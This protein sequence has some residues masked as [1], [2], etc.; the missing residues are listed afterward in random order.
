MPMITLK[1][2]PN[3]A[4]HETAGVGDPMLAEELVAEAYARAFARWRNVAKHPAPAAWVG[5]GSDPDYMPSCRGAAGAKGTERCCVCAQ[6]AYSFPTA[7]LEVRGLCFG[8]GD[9]RN[10]GDA[11]PGST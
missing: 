1:I 6:R 7:R 4:A 10:Q 5:P 2:S 3:G 11:A 9:E 8:Y